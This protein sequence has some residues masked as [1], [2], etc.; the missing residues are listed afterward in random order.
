MQLQW[1]RR[2]VEGFLRGAESGELS[3]SQVPVGLF[4]YLPCGSFLKAGDPNMDCNIL[5]SSF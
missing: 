1:R 5:E 4:S 3:Q 2:V